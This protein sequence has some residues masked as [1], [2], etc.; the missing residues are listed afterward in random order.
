MNKWTPCASVSLLGI[1][2]ILQGCGSVQ[3]TSQVVAPSSRKGGI[4][5]LSKVAD[6]KVSGGSALKKQ[7]QEVIIGTM[8]IGII[9]D[10]TAR[11]TAGSGVGRGKASA[12]AHLLGLDDDMMK[13]I[14]QEAY[15]QLTKDLEAQGYTV[16]DREQIKNE[17]AYQAL[18]EIGEDAIAKD[19]TPMQALTCK[20]VYVAPENMNVVF[21]PGDQKTMLGTGGSWAAYDKS[22]ALSKATGVSVLAANY[23]ISFANAES[24]GGSFRATAA[25]KIGQGISVLPDSSIMLFTGAGK[26]AVIKLGQAVYSTE[27]FS[28]IEK[29]TS[30]T[31]KAVRLASNV[32]SALLGGG[33]TQSEE[34][35]FSAEPNAYKKIAV[36]VISRSDQA[37]IE[38]IAEK[39]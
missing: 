3:S 6:V 12:R 1:I 24:H 29:V 2:L 25:V 18:Q 4:L 19:V 37:L 13:S 9:T 36:D 16:L 10:G 14:A 30:G 11:A 21:F 38:K 8:K 27:E 5:G 33:T 26:P 20:A 23:I 7:T 32:A 34:Y 17:P 15:A 28:S 22:N 39:K 31:E 35:N